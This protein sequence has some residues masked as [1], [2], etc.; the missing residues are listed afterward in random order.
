[1]YAAILRRI[2]ERAIAAG[3]AG[4]IEPLL[5][6]YA[7]DVEF[8]FHGNNSWATHTTGKAAVEAWLRRFAKVGLQVHPEEIVVKGPPWNTRAYIRFNDHLDAPGGE[9][10]YENRGVIFGRARWGK[11]TYYEVFEDTEKVAALD[12]WLSVNEPR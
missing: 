1:M 8:H 6:N 5:R 7:D 2:L 4:D 12:D 11:V 9:R 10:V 3:R